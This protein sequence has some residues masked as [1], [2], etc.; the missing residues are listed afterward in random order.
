V[1]I[2]DMD[3]GPLAP[4]TSERTMTLDLVK[5]PRR[6]SADRPNACGAFLKQSTASKS[7]RRS[8]VGPIAIMRATS[9][10]GQRR[11]CDSHVDLDADKRGYQNDGRSWRQARDRDGGVWLE[12]PASR[13]TGPPRR[14]PPSAPQVSR[15]G[16]CH[17]APA[18]VLSGSGLARELI[19]LTRR[20]PCQGPSARGRPRRKP[21]AAAG[22]SRSRGHR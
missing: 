16:A 19:V 20:R 5:E 22:F 7:G 11:Q 1:S 6:L 14:S 9:S 15:P 2:D 8:S 3:G 10:T 12:G 18:M 21:D 13:G 17:E 4:M